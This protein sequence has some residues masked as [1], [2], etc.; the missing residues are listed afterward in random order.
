MRACVW[1]TGRLGVC[2]E[3]VRLVLFIQDEMRMCLTAL[4]C[5][6]SLGP[7]HTST[8]PYKRHDFRKK[9]IIEHKMCV[10]IFFGTC[11]EKHFSF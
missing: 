8:L 4:S 6:A 1:L 2:I 5:V 10:L 9:K 11:I 7:P 3:C